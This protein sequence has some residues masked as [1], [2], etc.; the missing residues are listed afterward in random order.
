MK[1]LRWQLLIVVLALGAIAVL[2]YSQST[3]TEVPGA[4]PDIIASPLPVQGGFYSEGLIGTFSRLNP[5]LAFHNSADRDI[6]RLLYSRMLTFD[7]Q[8]FPEGELAE[9]WGI[10]QDGLVYNFSLHRNAVWHDGEPLTTADILF[11]IELLRD[12]DLPVPD[13]IRNLWTQV[14][15]TALSDFDISF[16]L[17]EPFTPFMDYLSF[18]IVPEH[19]YEGM[20]AAEFIDSDRHLAPLGSGPYAFDGF[21]LEQEDIVGVKLLAFDDYFLERAFIDRV[22]FYYFAEAQD[23]ADAYADGQIRAI[24]RIPN[25]ILGQAL[26]EPDLSL[27]SGRLPQ[28]SMVLLNLDNPEVPFFQELAV[29]QALMMALNRERMVSEFMGGQAIVANGPILAGSWAY[30]G[31][32]E[33]GGYAPEQADARLRSAGYSIPAAGGSIRSKDDVF[34]EFTLVH[35]EGAIYNQ[36][37]ASI[38][39]SWQTLGIAVTLLEVPYE[40]LISDHLDT[41]AYQAALIDLNYSG[42]YDP[43]PYPFWHQTQITGGQNYSQWDDRVASEYLEQARVIL[44]LDERIRLYRNFQVRF[45]RELPALPLFYPVYSFAVDPEIQ[46][47]RVGP[48]FDTSDRL[49]GLP[50]WF[51]SAANNPNGAEDQ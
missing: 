1:K 19:V 12:P 33:I 44:N 24:S 7:A 39:E 8:G 21:I 32:D 25:E 42:Q 37:A 4:V 26:A 40:E 50:G 3:P 27:Y 29:R 47:V 10:S 23:A 35:P 14:D 16:K 13:D 20:S 22:E 38:Q 9:S 11:T 5:V 17:P 2:L 18:G 41:R 36:V 34:L 43:D 48:L 6:N 30:L 15:V 49:A 46:G 31:V 51:L 28:V 45:A